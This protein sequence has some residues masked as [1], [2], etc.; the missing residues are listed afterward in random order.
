M[1]Q[2]VKNAVNSQELMLRN[3]VDG[4][5]EITSL[6]LSLAQNRELALRCLEAKQALAY[7]FDSSDDNQREVLKMWIKKDYRNLLVLSREQLHKDLVDL[8]LFAKFVKAASSADCEDVS[9]SRS[10]NH[11]AVIAYNYVTKAGETVCYF[12]KAL[13]LPTNLKTQ[14]TFRLKITDAVKLVEKIDAEL[15]HVDLHL[16]MGLINNAV[17]DSVREVLL[18]VIDGNQLNYYDLPR[19]FGVI[20]EKL[21]AVLGEKLS[22]G[23]LEVA[24]VRIVNITVPDN[25]S[26][27]LE[28]QY[29]ALAEAERIKQ[30]EN[31]VEEESLRLY[32][33]KASIHSKYP[34]FPMTL[35]EAEKDFALNRY[36]KRIGKDKEMSTEIQKEDL[37]ERRDEGKG[38]VTTVTIAKPEPPVMPVANHT[39]RTVY[40]VLVCLFAVVGIVVG[41]VAK[42]TAAGLAILVVT[43]AAALVVGI[44]FRARFSG[45]SASA[46]EEYNRQME[47]YQKNLAEYNEKANEVNG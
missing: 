32:E 30:F 17:N 41:T 22:D 14:A 2:N 38:S 16:A 9:V 26:E 36:L 34:Q 7:K 3:I 47:Q 37:E 39:F 12:D 44:V 5:E 24:D 19:Y 35:T 27:K 40:A 6:D 25:T 42:Q 1:E 45:I 4:K 28:Q 21:V 23:G 18:D 33:M 15:S 11:L 13:G 8:Y 46:M 31:K 20:R 43:V 10:Y 29:F